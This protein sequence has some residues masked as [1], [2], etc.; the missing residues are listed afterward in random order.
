METIVNNK[1]GRHAITASALLLGG[2]ATTLSVPPPAEQPPLAPPVQVQLAE[3]VPDAFDRVVAAFMA[4]GFT[5]DRA[6]RST[7]LI[8]TAGVVGD[9]YVVSNMFV[10]MTGI[11]TYFYRAVITPREVG[12][13]VSLNV[14]SR[15]TMTSN[16]K[17][18]PPQEELPF[19]QCPP[20]DSDAHEICRTNYGKIQVR[21]E[22]IAARLRN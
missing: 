2:C 3:P 18:E 21:L 19:R 4:E 5:V 7:G 20:G 10:T 6:D 12:S 13:T 14:T 1:L 17:P 9:P 16:G 15:H 11:P 22:Q 8:K